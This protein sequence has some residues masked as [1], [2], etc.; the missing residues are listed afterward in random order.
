MLGIKSFQVLGSVDEGMLMPLPGRGSG[1]WREEGCILTCGI[2]AIS[3]KIIILQI[4]TESKSELASKIV[5][6]ENT[7]Q[8]TF[9]RDLLFFFLMRYIYIY[10]YAYDCFA[11][12]YLC[13]LPMCLVHMCHSGQ[14]SHLSC[15]SW[16]CLLV[17]Q[18]PASQTWTPSA[19]QG[20]HNPQTLLA[21]VSGAI[22]SHTVFSHVFWWFS[23]STCRCSSCSSNTSWMFRAQASF[24]NVGFPCQLW[25]LGSR[26]LDGSTVE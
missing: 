11:C 10:F 15:L 4:E 22:Y 1:L 3:L 13:A 2:I 25:T 12:L 23:L 26:R 18:C 21:Q 7:G 17:F 24:M 19:A 9:C 6:I 8:G 5:E 16:P 14:L 20:Q